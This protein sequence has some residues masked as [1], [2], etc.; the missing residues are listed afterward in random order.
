MGFYM[1]VNSWLLKKQI[2]KKRKKKVTLYLGNAGLKW[3]M[4][5]INLQIKSCFPTDL[6]SIQGVIVDAAD[7]AVLITLYYKL[8]LYIK[9]KK[10]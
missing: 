5:F 4:A 10:F 2:K 6:P 8:Q 1:N 3:K 9:V 7:L